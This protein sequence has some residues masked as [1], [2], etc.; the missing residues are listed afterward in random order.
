MLAQ[1]I[2]QDID[3]QVGVMRPAMEVN[4]CIGSI[5]MVK[6]SCDMC[7]IGKDTHTQ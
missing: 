4:I 3:D 1:D 6:G 7:P 5:P 2:H